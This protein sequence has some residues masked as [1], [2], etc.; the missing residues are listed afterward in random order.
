MHMEI[1]PS[2][3][4]ACWLTDRNGSRVNPCAPN[5]ISY[6]VLPAARPAAG[7]DR[8]CEI[9]GADFYT[10]VLMEG[11]AAYSEDGQEPS[12]PIPF[13]IR[14]RI[15]I[16]PPEG[17]A[18]RCSVLGFACRAIPV[19]RIH[20]RTE[21]RLVIDTLVQIEK[22][23]TL[24][25]PAVWGC[26]CYTCGACPKAIPDSVIFRSEVRILCGSYEVQEDVY[27][28]NAL[29]DGKKRIY[30]D[31]DEL[32]P[33]GDRGIPAPGSVSYYNLFVNGV[34]QP[35]ANYKIQ[36]GI[37]EFL[38][39]DLPGEKQ[40]IS[41]VVFTVRHCSGVRLRAGND[42]YNAVSDGIKRIFTNADELT[43]YG[44][45]GIPS[46]REVSY[47]NLFINGVLQ[48]KKNYTVRKGAMELNTQDIPL[49]EAILT[50]ESVR[51]QGIDHQLVKS[52]ANL[53]NAYSDGRKIYTDSDEIPVYG[54]G[55]IPGPKLYSFQNLF[56]NAMVQPE[57]N[58]SVHRG[59]LRLNT[60][61][62]PLEK[63]PITLQSVRSVY[64]QGILCRCRCEI[65]QV[66]QG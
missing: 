59:L 13:R 6:T 20:R 22:T 10:T 53:Y 40:L 60:E 27:Q 66:C 17:C 55:G 44:N 38:T 32:I 51:I 54:N 9:T 57:I 1:Q 49:P 24:W 5:A 35:E 65:L 34:L 50:L 30:T 18:I 63:S 62:A 48:P 7:T 21:L 46:P 23:G 19:C 31:G 39:E 61:D 2:E 29:S 42:T 16:A 28:Y 33:Y 26:F 3:S 25:F 47:F 41:L 12:T 36:E 58:Y 43:A 52:E 37:L 4:P 45:K 64:S 11:C 15:P 56:V 8:R 14:N